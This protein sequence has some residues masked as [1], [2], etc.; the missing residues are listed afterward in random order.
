MAIRKRFDLF[1]N[2]RPAKSIAEAPAV[3]DPLDIIVVRENEGGMYCGEGQTLSDD[4][5]HAVMERL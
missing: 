1:A 3:H 2:V 4:F 5:S